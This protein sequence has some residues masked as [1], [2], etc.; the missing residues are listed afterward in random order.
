MSLGFDPGT[1]HL[2]F[3]NRTPDGNFAYK[4]E[5]NAFLEIPLDN[6]FVFNMMKSSG[7]PLIERENVAY[8]LG[9]AAVNMAYTMSQIELKRPMIHGCVNP[10][11]K[12]AFQIMS[13]MIHSLIENVKKDGETLYYC[14]P[15]NAIN[16]ETDADYHQR[17]LD[18]IFKAYKSETGYRVD[19]HPINEALALVY[20]ELGKKAF[21]GIGVS[22]L[23]PGTKIYTKEGIKNIENVKIGD[24]V[25]T[26]KGRWR[27]VNN[28]INKQFKGLQTK[29]QLSGYSNNTEDYGFVDNHE[30]YVYRNNEWKWIGCEEVVEGEIVGEPIEKRNPNSETLAM[31]ICER[32]NCSKEYTKKRVEISGDV[33]RLLGYFLADGSIGE[34]EGCIQFDFQLN[35]ESNLSDVEEILKNNFKKQSSRTKHGDNCV[36]VKCYSRGLANY[37][38]KF[39]NSTKEKCL[40]W[41][42]SR[43]SKSDCINLLA[44]LIRGD[45]TIGEDIISFENTSSSLAILVKQLFSKIGIPA[46]ISYAEPRIGKPLKNGKIISGKKICWRVSSG[47]KTTFQSLVQIIE[48]VSCDNSSHVE[49]LFLM[50]GM[51]CGRIQK[52]EHDDYE[53]IVY[54]LQVDEDHSFSGPM[55]TIHNCGAGMVNVC[56][57]MYG[58]PVFSFSIVN[59]GDWIDRQAAKATG[60]TVAFINVE[61]TK[62]DLTKPA[63]SLVERAIQTQYRLM[64]ENTVSG[65]KKGFADVSKTVRTDAPVDVV[66]AGGTS[67]PNGFIE[68]FQEVVDQTKLP[69]KLGEIIKPDDPLFSV[70]RGCLIAAEAAK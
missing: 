32:T 46:S 58:N 20:A 61:K 24:L 38:R 37:F 42:L 45:G 70:A 22:C 52:I 27:P 51:C 6:R 11:E 44:G 64:I 53:G 1:Y 12:D 67:S 68:M 40:P 33:W 3:C 48:E 41:D 65:I 4:K 19:A 26:H 17:I 54:D 57:A 7:V 28:V 56:Y 10:K 23:C 16:Q 47:S 15:A 2:V 69:I 5:V 30:L 49:K 18:A 31:T 36:R 63:T 35:E 43:L 50:D 29:L 60:E 9:E 21:T 14:V 39:Y 34:E 66:I 8:A 25:L 59:S 13:I 55:L 62:V